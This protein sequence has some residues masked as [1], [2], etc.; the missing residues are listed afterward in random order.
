MN[1]AVSRRLSIALLSLLLMFVL[2]S[3]PVCPAYSVLTHEEIIDLCWDQQIKP[4]LLA[5]FPNATDQ[6]L[7]KAHAYAYG[8]SVIQ[9]IGYY[10][11]G[12]ETFSDLTH[13]VRTGDFVKAMIDD[14][15]D[16]NEYAF[17]LGALSHYEAD[18]NG[19]PYINLSVGIE[20]PSLAREYGPAVPYD[21]DHKA[22][23]RTEF[24]FDVLQVAKGRYASE[25]YHN[26]IGFEVSAPLLERA[27]LDTYGVPLKDVMPKEQTA[28][29]TYRKSVSQVI[30]EMTKVALLVK[31]DQLQREIPNFN[32][33]KFLY[34]L[35]NADYRKA[36]GGGYKEPGP[37]ARIMAE[38]FKVAPKV[39]PLRAIDFKEPTEKTENLY[40]KSVD[41]TVDRYREALKQ[42]HAGDLKSPEINLDTGKPTT[43]DQYPLADYTYR[44]LLD[45]LANDFTHMNAGVQASVLRFYDG[46]GFPD[47]QTRINNCVV[48]RWQQ[49]WLELNQIRVLTELDQFDQPA[50]LPPSATTT[51]QLTRS[52][53]ASCAE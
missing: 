51:A 8:G 7:L 38:L 39:G 18:I 12:D 15:Q 23:I 20:Y 28:I 53:F 29:N 46:F 25:D 26:F 10:P 34:H 31:G 2:V 14:S 19:H 44:N 43:R 22:H 21:V 36:W 52:A 45:A 50:K 32:R 40:F 37:G 24:G 47:P 3:A 9:D 30:P 49:T 16:I 48:K 41:Q 6:D 4:L 33:Q 17:A 5:R 27:F 13:Y 42:V 1:V 35:S 11:F